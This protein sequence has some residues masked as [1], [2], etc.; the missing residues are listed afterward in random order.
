MQLED[1]LFGD[2]GKKGYLCTVYLT[3]DFV[4]V[5][6]VLEL[7]HLREVKE[8]NE[9]QEVKDVSGWFYKSRIGE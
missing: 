6:Q 9:V 4:Q 8:D 5:S 3:Y 2:V 1:P 7:A